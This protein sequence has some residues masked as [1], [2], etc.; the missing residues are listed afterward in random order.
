MNEI[1]NNFK[2]YI[3]VQY[4]QNRLKHYKKELF[5]T[6]PWIQSK[7]LFN[8]INSHINVLLNA[9]FQSKQE[10][11]LRENKYIVDSIFKYT[12]G[13]SENLLKSNHKAKNIKSYMQLHSYIIYDEITKG[14]QAGKSR[15]LIQFN[16]EKQ[17]HGIQEKINS[18][19]NMDEIL[20]SVINQ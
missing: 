3:L 7:S 20:E 1:T 17:L 18:N 14:L 12:L 4:T 6:L 11:S 5:K 2:R 10:Q 9:L 19:V 15:Q 8:T 16:I 13:R